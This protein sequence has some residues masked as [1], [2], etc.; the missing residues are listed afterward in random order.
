MTKI[1]KI[2][3]DDGFTAYL[4]PDLKDRYGIVFCF[5]AR[6]G[7]C[8]KGKFKSLNIDYYTGDS[9]ENV[10]KNREKLLA[11][12]GL[13]GMKKIYSVK[14]VHGNRILYI[15]KDFIP[16]TDN[17]RVEADSLITDLKNTPVMVMGADCNL[18][19]A[20]DKEKK[21]IAA[22]HAGWRG[23]LRKIITKVILYMVENFKSNKKNIIVAFGPGIR[24][25]CYRVDVP[26]LEEFKKKFGSGDFFTLKEDGIYLDLAVVNYMQLKKLGLSEENILD[27]C[28]CTGCNHD[29]FSY[30]RN[31]ETGRQAAVA[32]IL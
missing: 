16:D 15:N 28:E 23:T 17:I 9:P 20:A 21:V 11:G 2:L 10:K 12:I 14:Q 29:F 32:V 24:K 4:S 22:V 3:S 5:S 6:Y 27:C 19:L 8:S 7:G 31:K 30:R 13:N 18:M 25:C 1:E 26:V